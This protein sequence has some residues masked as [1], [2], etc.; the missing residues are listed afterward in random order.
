[1]Q[2]SHGL[3][4]PHQ[5]HLAVDLETLIRYLHLVIFG[6][7]ECIQCGTERATVQAVQQHM[8][9]KG[10]CR[11]D[12]LEEDS[13]FADFYDFGDSVESDIDEETTANQN[14]S[15]PADEDSIRLP[16]GKTIS[17]KPSAQAEQP[18]FT[19]PHRRTTSTFPSQI[20]YS[21]VE[22]DEEENK[23]ATDTSDSRALS[24][25]E[26]REKAMITYQLA[27]MTANDRSSLMHLPA[28]QQRAMLAAQ[29]R[30]ADKIQKVERR[31]QTR[32]ERK[33]NKNLYAY[34]NTETPVYQCG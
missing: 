9:G 32:I 21:V 19:R 14:Q 25:R 6:Y 4:I 12:I 15:L 27:N 13:E 28:S 1:M 20:E 17:K 2:K 23:E 7:R 29:H 18:L 10:H 8:L 11:F 33:G 26:K 3:F 22:Y 34:W 30:H 5:Q 24:R 16:S 31:R